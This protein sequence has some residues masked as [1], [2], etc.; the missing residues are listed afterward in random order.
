MRLQRLPGR[1]LRQESDACVLGSWLS[2]WILQLSQLSSVALFDAMQSIRSFQ[3]LSNDWAPSRWSSAASAAS[4]TPALA[5][6]AS[7]S[8]ASPPSAGRTLTHLAVIGE[9]EQRLLGHRVDGVRGRER[10]DVKDIR[11]LGIF[12]AG[13]G[14]QQALRLRSGAGKLSASGARRADRGRLCTCAWRWQSRDDSEVPLE[15][16][17]SPPCPSG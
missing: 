3:D 2:S 9:G 4:S 1:S 16:F 5:N 10:L 14:P 7:T 6:S 17:P 8:S 13:A 11:S 15:P 12:G